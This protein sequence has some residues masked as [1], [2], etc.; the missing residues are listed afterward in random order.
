[1][2]Y[3]GIDFGLRRI[4]LAI[5]EYGQLATPWKV[6]EVSSFKDALSKFKEILSENEFDKII[7]G[8]PEGRIGKT[9]LGFI[10]ALKKEG[11]NVESADE[12][13]SSKKAITHMIELK[14][15]KNKRRISDAYSAAIILQNYLDIN[16]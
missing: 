1:M 12:T 10:K 13:L 5:S 15:A 11:L 7:V 3:L 4:G 6:L 2:R 8:L 9:A 14:I 16:S